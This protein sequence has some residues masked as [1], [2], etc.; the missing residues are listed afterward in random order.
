MSNTPW[1]NFEE[2]SAHLKTTY[3]VDVAAGTIENKVYEQ[4]IPSTLIAG[5]RR[6]HRER[7]DEWALKEVSNEDTGS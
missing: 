2:A 5:R 1:L 7:L 4:N 6:I 3:G